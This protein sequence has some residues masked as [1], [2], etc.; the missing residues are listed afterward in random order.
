M[1]G[2]HHQRRSG[3]AVKTPDRL[4][5]LLAS[6]D[7][8]ARESLLRRNPHLVEQ[9]NQEVARARQI[10]SRVT[11]DADGVI[12]LAFNGMKLES[13]MNVRE[14]WPARQA[15]AK[16]QRRA[17][18]GALASIPRP[19]ANW[20]KVEITRLGPRPLDTDNRDGSAKHVRDAV[21]EWLGT[22]DGV[23]APVEWSVTQLKS[24]TYGCLVRIEPVV[25]G[26]GR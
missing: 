20:W 16:R 23:S 10:D 21:A 14:F 9:Y 11:I 15:R 1:A 8:A 25:Q 2:A 12:H 7:D 24:K 3:R 13:E 17:A 4:R 18:A 5:A 22:G 6:L 19:V 26:H